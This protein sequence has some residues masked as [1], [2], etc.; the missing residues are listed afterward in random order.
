MVAAR[1]MIGPSIRLRVRALL[2]YGDGTLGGMQRDLTNWARAV[3]L[4]RL[5]GLQRRRGLS[6]EGL[7]R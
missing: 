1:A 5:P 7:E 3:D 6:P 2:F 4:T